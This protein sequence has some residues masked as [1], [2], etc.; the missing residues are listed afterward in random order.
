MSLLLSI[1]P[2][3]FDGTIR[4]FVDTN[5]FDQGGVDCVLEGN[6]RDQVREGFSYYTGLPSSRVPRSSAQ[7]RAFLILNGVTDSASHDP[8]KLLYFSQSYGSG[9]KDEV[10]GHI[11][12]IMPGDGGGPGGLTFSVWLN[13]NGL[14]ADTSVSGDADG[15]GLSNGV[16]FYLDRPPLATELQPLSIARVDE[17]QV[18]VSYTMGQ[19]RE[20]VIASLEGSDDCITWSTVDVPAKD[21][22]IT[23]GEG[24]DSAKITLPVN[25]VQFLR[26]T[27]AVE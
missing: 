4:D 17:T 9:V 3:G 14:P 20:G 5:G 6:Q 25:G 23:P 12:S 21:W 16:E 10:L 22:V 8:W 1:E 18:S 15:D 7:R 24:L 11:N 26:L 13:D 2:D 27:V 19:N